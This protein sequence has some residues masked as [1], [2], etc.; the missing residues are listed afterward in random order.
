VFISVGNT[1]DVRYIALLTRENQTLNLMLYNF[2]KY[3]LN[4]AKLS[5]LTKYCLLNKRGK[6]C[7][8]LFLHYTDIVIFVLGHLIVTHPICTSTILF[9]LTVAEPMAKWSRPPFR[10]CSVLV[11]VLSYGA[12]KFIWSYIV[13]LHSAIWQHKHQHIEQIGNRGRLHFAIGSATVKSKS[14]V[15]VHRPDT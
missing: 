15:E 1:W 13:P 7:A 10:I 4:S 8:K 14:M 2:A 6:F 11:F 3:K 12:M 5:R 9:D